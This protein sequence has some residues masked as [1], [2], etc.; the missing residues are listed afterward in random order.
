MS[1]V[2]ILFSFLIVTT[3]LSSFF[4]STRGMFINRTFLN[5][6][7]SLFE[8]NVLEIGNEESELNDLNDSSLLRFNENSLLNLNNE[9]EIHFYFDKSGIENDV[10]NYLNMNLKGKINKY[11]IGFKYYIYNESSEINEYFGNNPTG[12]QIRFK[13]NYY[14]NYGF[15]SYISFYIKEGVVN[16]NEWKAKKLFREFF[17]KRVIK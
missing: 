9:E 16:L 13:A 5:M 15:D 14:Q 1:M 10:K 11:Q 8:A 2:P 6:P 4:I 12:V 3:F 7:L 17:F